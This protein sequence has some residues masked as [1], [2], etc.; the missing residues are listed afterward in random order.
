MGGTDEGRGLVA[1]TSYWRGA[2]SSLNA[3]LTM[4]VHR[5]STFPSL[6][7]DS[8]PLTLARRP[9]ARRSPLTSTPPRRA[10][11]PS[12]FVPPPAALSPV[13]L[14]RCAASVS[15]SLAVP[16]SSSDSTCR[17]AQR[18]LLFR[19]PFAID[20]NKKNRRCSCSPSLS[21]ETPLSL[22][23]PLR[24]LAPFLLLL[25][26]ALLYYSWFACLALFRSDAVV[27]TSP[28]PFL[29]PFYLV[30]VYFFVY[31][32]IL[33]SSAICLLGFSEPFLTNHQVVQHKFRHFLMSFF[34]FAAVVSRSSYFLLYC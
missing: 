20:S 1:A 34:F 3:R 25:I 19:S 13:P 5:P 8:P 29:F 18:T 11:V 26:L 27:G 14:C 21:L 31:L 17:R 12:P 6:P 28:S 15:T 32:P 2:I 30:L 33:F 9:P 23:P 4:T 16:H 7:H 24:N 22:S 10:A